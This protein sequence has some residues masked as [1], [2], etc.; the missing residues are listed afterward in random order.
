MAKGN[1]TVSQDAQK[2]G[3]GSR[4]ERLEAMRTRLA[5]L[6]SQII[7]DPDDLRANLDRLEASSDLEQ[8][9]LSILDEHYRSR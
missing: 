9:A 5:A 1:S 4:T 8:T 2:D 3:K 6:P 7:M